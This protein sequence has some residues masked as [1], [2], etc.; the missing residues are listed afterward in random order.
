[1]LPTARRD[2]LAALAAGLY[3][4]ALCLAYNPPASATAGHDFQWLWTGARNLLAG[5]DPYTAAPLALYGERWGLLYPMPAVLVAMPLAGLGAALAGAA[6]FGAS[7]ALLGYAIA[8][9]RRWWMLGLFLSPAYL[10]AASSVQW[11]PLVTAATLLP[12][13]GFLLV[14]KPTI[15][16]AGFVYRPSWRA[17][18]GCTLFLAATFIIQP[19]WP[20]EWWRN[21]RDTPQPYLLPLLTGPG[22]LLALAALRW[23]TA[24][25]RFLLVSGLV[26]RMPYFYDVLPL[27]LVARD[28]LD[29]LVL[30]S[31]QW[32][33]FAG[34][35]ATAPPLTSELALHAHVLAWSITLGYLPALI[36]V[37]RRPN[38][39][40]LPVPAWLA[41]RLPAWLAGRVPTAGD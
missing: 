10:V 13:L 41:R 40:V 6:F 7:S 8:R 37:L 3:G 36:P 28:R 25:G 30:L 22:V 27:W 24:E 38:E 9:E 23:R 21:T 35:I 14:T 29:A 5:V 39:G 33:A 16:L 20:I 19:S 26:P 17:A 15:G 31:T 18:V 1:M 11:A 4:F 34:A 2:L 32:L 12:P